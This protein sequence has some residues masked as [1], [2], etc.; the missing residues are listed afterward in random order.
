M[1]KC[2]SVV[3]LVIVLGVYISQIEPRLL[4]TKYIRLSPENSNETIRL[5]QISDLHLCKQYSIAQL[6][7]I[8]RKVNEQQPDLIVFTGDFFDNYKT[9]QKIEEVL[10]VWGTLRG[11]LGKYAIWGNHDYG[12]DAERIYRRLMKETAFH[13][14]K[15]TGETI[16]TRQGNTIFIA[17]LDDGY[18]GA[19]DVEAALRN[20]ANQSYKIL[21]MHEPD[22]AERCHHK[23]LDLL[24]AGHSHGGQVK[25]PFLKRKTTDLARKYVIGFYTLDHTE[26]LYVNT[27]IGTSK[28]QVRFLTPPEITVFDIGLS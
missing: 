16:Q 9:Y 24:L 12:G 11:R 1:K 3:I 5:V 6:Q 13:L 27:G 20:K 17:G 22:L 2:I 26:R 19:P 4:V 28:W 15:N 8:V 14:L 10:P 21:L 7:K 18:F 25:I 23:G